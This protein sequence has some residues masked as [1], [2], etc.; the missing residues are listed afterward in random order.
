MKGTMNLNGKWYVRWT[1]GVR[2]KEEYAE[3]D[4]I[5]QTRYIAAVVPGEIHQIG[6]AH[7]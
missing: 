5:D 2:G 6:R 7:V 1:D 4:V 3:R